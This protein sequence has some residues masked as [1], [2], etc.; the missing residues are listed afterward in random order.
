MSDLF[1]IICV[2]LLLFLFLAGWLFQTDVP[3]SS[4]ERECAHGIRLFR[5][6]EGK[7]A[8]LLEHE[9]PCSLYEIFTPQFL[10]G[11]GNRVQDWLC[12]QAVK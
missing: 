9:K 12:F 10:M 3:E 5:Q 1:Y 2:I 11:G 7:Y 6:V 4:L 8:L